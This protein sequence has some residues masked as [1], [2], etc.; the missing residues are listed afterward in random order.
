MSSTTRTARTR[1]ARSLRTLRAGAV[2][3]GLALALTVSN[4][5]AS[6]FHVQAEVPAGA[7]LSDCSFTWVAAPAAAGP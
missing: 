1:T 5:T 3:A 7:V 2:V 6:G 4:T